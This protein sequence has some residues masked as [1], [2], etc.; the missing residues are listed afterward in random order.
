[1]CGIA[2]IYK[3][4]AGAPPV[5]AGELARMTRHL[6][7]RGPDGEGRWL[8]PHVGLAHRRLSI[9]DIEGGQQPIHNE[10]RSIW[11][12]FNGEIFNFPELRRDLE[13]A[14][15]RFYTRSDTEVIVHLYEEHGDDFVQHLNGQFA[16]ALWDEPAQR[17]LLVRDRV[18][19][20][21]LFYCSVGGRL[22]FASEAKALL[23]LLPSAPRL[24]PQALD[25]VMTFWA[26]L[27]PNTMFE[28]IY[29]LPPGEVLI[30]DRRGLGTRRY[31][32][33][34]FPASGTYNQAGENELTERLHDLL[35]DATRVRLRA[36]VPV[37]AY[38]SG[39]LD[40]SAIAALAQSVVGDRLKT[41]SIQFAD[42]S[43]DEGAYQ[44]AMVDHLGTDHS[45][46]LCG[47][48][49]I[50]QRLPEAVWRTEC[51]ILRTA[52]VPM[53][54]LSAHVR[55]Q[56]YK[57]VLTGEGADEALGGYDLFKEAKIRQFWAAQPDSRWRPLLL[58]RLYPYLD[59]TQ[60]QGQVYLQ[61]FFGMALDNP[62]LGYFSHLPRWI[63]TSKC[64]AF[65]SPALKQTLADDALRRLEEGLP[66]GFGE[67]HPLNRAQYLEVKLLM[68]GYLLSSQ[69][70]RMLMGN[71]VE[72][73]FPF[74]DHRL[75]EFANGLPPRMK[76]RALQ[77]KYLLKRAVQRYL[78]ASIS[79]RHKQPYR[80]PDAA[81]LFDSGA[82]GYVRELLSEEAIRRTGYFD[83]ARV[84][85][86]VKKA[87]AGRAVGQKDNMALVGIL[88]T[89]LWHHHFVDGWQHNFADTPGESLTSQET[90][91]GVALCQ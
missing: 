36:D 30:A 47:G 71:S 64:K 19:I 90:T 46:V 56:G 29:E 83:P 37:G 53:G 14:G 34:A 91:T 82:P 41:F 6:E 17:L 25:E 62:Q 87:R 72:G 16:I 35:L 1:M 42:R 68:A 4:H 70:D 51:P 57:V 23:P 52:P 38:L 49:E 89:Q 44:Q 26:P 86:L 18:G 75:I 50:A 5:E 77:E 66:R 7:R 65:L 48:A 67:L 84:A 27:S 73:R 20:A 40:S 8:R 3:L 2:G 15:H 28:G 61:Q 22:L 55:S 33:W 11:T 69:G 80:A 24:N 39:G 45:R 81:A 31:W 88:S 58:R 10:D 21:P 32:D 54:M 85:L 79:A 9:I 43:F 78:P 76:M 63:T 13:Q 60:R 74:L 12:V 59:M